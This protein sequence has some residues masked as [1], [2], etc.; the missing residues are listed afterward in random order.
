[1][2]EERLLGTKAAIPLVAGAML[3]VGIFLVPAQIAPH[4]P[5]A[6]AMY[7]VWIA[8]GLFCWMGALCYAELGVRFPR[9]GGDVVYIRELYGNQVALVIGWVIFAGIFAG[10]IAALAVPLCQFRL[11]CCK[12]PASLI[13]MLV[14]WASIQNPSGLWHCHIDDNLQHAW[15]KIVN[16]LSGA[17]DL[18][19]NGV[20]R[21]GGIGLSTVMEPSAQSHIEGASG[22]VSFGGIA[23]AVSG[24]YFAF[25]GWN[26]AGYVAGELNNP[27]Q[28]LPR[29]VTISVLS[30]TLLYVLLNMVFVHH[31]GFEYLQQVGFAE[32]GTLTA[33]QI[34]GEGLGWWMNLLILFGLVGSLNGTILCGARVGCSMAKEGGL[35]TW[36][37]KYSNSNQPVRVLIFQAVISIGYILT[38]TFEQ[39]LEL[40]SLA[41]IW[42][43]W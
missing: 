27:R 36:F 16:G 40:V 42:L 6:A 21:Y 26:Q 3:G 9:I 20:V 11:H 41:M 22:T 34:G 24:C 25:S 19:P 28:T 30:I 32:V 7:G 43:P 23:I 10:S 38:G 31:L 12:V 35:S 5:S 29:T 4:M 17:F 15:A 14:Y 1:M 8:V 18:C 37:S 33:K 2:A 39:L 13:G